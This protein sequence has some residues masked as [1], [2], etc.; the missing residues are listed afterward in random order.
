[1]GTHRMI[2][3]VSTKFHKIPPGLRT[4]TTLSPTTAP[5]PVCFWRNRSDCSRVLTT[6]KGLVTMAPHIPPRLYGEKKNGRLD[7]KRDIERVV[8][9]CVPSCKKVL[10]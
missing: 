5:T 3:A 10:P 8:R 4:S 1:M 7:E 6:S 2:C 9:V